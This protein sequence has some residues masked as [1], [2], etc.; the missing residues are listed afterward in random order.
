MSYAHFFRRVKEKK[1][2]KKVKVGFPRFK[3]KVSSMTFPQVGFK[4]ND[5]KLYVSKIGEIPMKM[6]RAI[7]G[8]IK[9]FT[10]KVN[11]AN[12]WHACFSCELDKKE[13]IH[14]SIE[15]V[16]ID[17]GLEYF[18]TLSNG[19]HI[20][21]PRC[22]AKSQNNLHKQQKRLSRKKK[23]S[24]NRRKQ[25]LKVAMVHNKVVN[26]RSDFLHKLSYHLAKSY[27][28]IAVEN[29]QIK[30]MIKNHHLA[31]SISD[32]SWGTFINHLSYKAVAC[33]G[34]I[35]KVEPKGT[36]RKCSSCGKEIDMP[37]HK[38]QFDCPSCGLVLHRDTNSAIN[39]LTDGRAGQARTYTLVDR[40][41]LLFPS[42]EKASGLVEARTL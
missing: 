36:S 40:P 34:Q 33:G 6:H 18:A 27:S 8:K 37:L 2:G 21:N 24:T 41:P 4:I 13:V 30:N 42:L 29:L 7:K 20:E 10:I 35:V 3:C 23:G 9:T 22:L 1:S 39:I 5:K 15:S 38:R 25:K 12:Q 16:G 28:F 31:K 26:Q 11:P 32:A 17:V 14:P 19:E